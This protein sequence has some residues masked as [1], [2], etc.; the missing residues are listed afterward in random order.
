ME[1]EKTDSGC[2]IVGGAIKFGGYDWIVLDVENGKALLLSDRIIKVRPYHSAFEDITWAECELRE[3]LNGAFLEGFA[4]HDKSNIAE[5][6]TVTNDNPWYGTNG[7]NPIKDRLFLLSIE[8]LS[9]YFGNSSRLEEGPPEDD[10][11]IGCIDDQYNAIR[12]ACD[13]SGNE[14]WWWLRSPGK[15]STYAAL[16][17]D[18][19]E[20]SVHGPFIDEIFAFGAGVRPALWLNMRLN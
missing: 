7:G 9:K 20:I 18:E 8:E 3:Y 2:I 10:D 11:S 19:G 13:E 16:V 6:M 4:A 14:S 1:L 15:L 5:T 17:T 12:V